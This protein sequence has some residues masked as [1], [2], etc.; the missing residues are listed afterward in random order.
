MAARGFDRREVLTGSTAAILLAGLSP[1]LVAGAPPGAGFTRE[2]FAALTGQWFHVDASGW[3][4]ARL[5]AVVDG[6]AARSTEQFT[7]VFRT[8]SGRA[9]PEGTYTLAPPTGDPF[10]LFLQPARGSAVDATLLASFSLLP[11]LPFAGCAGAP[12]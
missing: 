2:G 11:A 10:P 6:A 4:S 8:A 12:A 5:V 1:W 3:E 9:L 7:L